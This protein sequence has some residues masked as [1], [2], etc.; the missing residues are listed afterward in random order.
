MFKNNIKCVMRRKKNLKNKYENLSNYLWYLK[1][2]KHG[3]K[4]KLYWNVEKR[5]N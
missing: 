2:N 3:K 5:F 1:I 4:L